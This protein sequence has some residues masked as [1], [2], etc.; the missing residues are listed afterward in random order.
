M[1]RLER[2]Q[3]QLF[4]N[5]TLPQLDG[6]NGPGL[7]KPMNLLGSPGPFLE[8]NISPH[9][10]IKIFGQNKISPN[11]CVA[12]ARHLLDPPLSLFYYYYYFFHPPEN[13]HNCA[14]V[15]KSTYNTVSLLDPP[16]QL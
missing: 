5:P 15:V 2:C 11:V 14:R 6:K 9:F 4:K 12:R 10:L 16:R 1:R 3:Y 7:A 8:R 13:L